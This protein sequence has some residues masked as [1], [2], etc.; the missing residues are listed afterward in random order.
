MVADFP[1]AA[2]RVIVRL[3]VTRVAESCGFGVPLYDYVGER[4]GMTSW[5]DRK[6]EEGVEEYQRDK[7]GASIDGL[8]GLAWVQEERS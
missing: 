3:R 2:E 4:E 5:R 1:G 6:G 7:N 8:D